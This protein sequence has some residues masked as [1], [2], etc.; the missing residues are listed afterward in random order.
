MQD[1]KLTTILLAKNGR[2]SSS[3][4]TKHINNRYFM[5]EDKIGKG[6]IAIQYCPTGD[7]LADINTKALQ[8]ALFYKM[9]T[10]LMGISK[11][12]D[13]KVERLNTQPVLLP[14]KDCGGPTMSPEDASVLTK[15]G[16]LKR[17]SP[18]LPKHYRRHPR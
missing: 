2:F 6:E 8:G 13:D 5:I 16:T 9:R 18:L 17:P 3:K 7:M 4:R 11:N 1:N 10:R 15:T 12:Y 14:L